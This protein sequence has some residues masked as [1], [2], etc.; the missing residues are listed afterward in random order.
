[1]TDFVFW[2][3]RDPHRSTDGYTVGAFCFE[4]CGYLCD[5]LEDKD[6]GLTDAMSLDEIK[7]RKV[8]GETAIPRGRYEVRLDIVSPRLKDR[9]Y[10]KKYGGCLPRLMNVKGFDGI[11]IHPFTSAS[12]SKG[13]IGPGEFVAKT[14]KIVRSTQAFYDMMDRYLVPAF[15]RGQRIYLEID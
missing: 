3:H 6:R 9:A 7:A 5:S 2:L 12:E 4:E 1:M 13:C 15:R 14:G 8:Y 10:A 11:L